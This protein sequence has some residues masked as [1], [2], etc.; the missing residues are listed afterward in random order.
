MRPHAPTSPYQISDRRGQGQPPG[1]PMRRRFHAGAL[2]GF[3]SIVTFALLALTLLWCAPVRAAFAPFTLASGDPANGLQ[4]D[5]AYDPTVSANGQYVAFTGS[6]ASKSGVYRKDLATGELELVAEGPGAGAPS[7]SAEGRYVS[8]TTDEEPAAS[9]EPTSLKQSTGGCTSVYVR[10]MDISART[11]ISTKTPGAYTLASATNGSSESLAYEPPE[12]PGQP[13]GA[14]A[15]SRVALSGNGRMVAFTILSASDLTGEAE[16]HCATTVSPTHCP[17]PPDEVAVRNLETRSTTL[18]SVTAASLGGTQQPVPG[19]AALAG[20][21]Y[22]GNFDLP[23]GG[24]LTLPI[25]ASTA[26]ISADGNAVAW[27]GIHIPEQAQAASLPDTNGYRLGYAEPLWRQISGGPSSPTRRVLAGD[28]PSA[29][30]CP[31]TCPG[32]LDLDW[33]TQ[34]LNEYSG[35]APEYG[36]Y[37]ALAVGASSFTTGGGFGDQLAAVTPQLSEDG[38]EV[39]L[40]STQP[41]YGE[42]PNFGLLSHLEPPPANA[43]VVNMAPGL[44]RAQ[45]ITRL[46]EWGS[47]NFLDQALAGAVTSITISPDGTRVAFTTERIAFP[48]APPALITPPVSQANDVQLYEANLRSGTLALVTQGYDGQPANDEIFGSALSGDGEVLALAS[49]ATNLTYGTVSEGSD[50]FTTREEDSPSVAGQQSVTPLPSGPTITPQWAI[51]ATAQPAPGGGA[52]LI[53]ISVPG[54]G[55]LHLSARA[56]VPVAS[57]RATR[58][59]VRSRKHATHADRPRTRVKDSATMVSAL[60]TAVM[61]AVVATALLAHTHAVATVATRVVATA[62]S[63][64]ADPEVVQL[65]LTPASRYRSLLNHKGGLFA[66]L[67]VTFS[68]PGHHTISQTLQASFTHPYPLYRVPKYKIPK[69]KHRRRRKVKRGAHK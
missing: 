11:P 41:T 19:G 4:A 34:E 17:T 14:A 35:A 6:V 30:D 31:P 23:D 38:N 58:R 42:D 59:G 8:F 29:F 44:T 55:R 46:T 39:A 9:E 62:N 54:A 13:C 25:S 37:I 21:T 15:A 12:T 20:T 1:R 48:L 65:R 40:L 45:A 53:D 7:I 47:L 26:A 27:M 67:V 60:P 50:V 61:P 2:V 5:Y 64:T 10:D 56:A 36:S 68:A 49:G 43:F 3:T 24:E 33:D 16:G 63:V 69:P 66:T 52:L 51:S 22:S 57:P 28:D 32:G 18:V